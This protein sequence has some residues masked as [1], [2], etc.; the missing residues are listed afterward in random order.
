MNEPGT[1]TLPASGR[2]AKQILRTMRALRDQDVDWEEGRAL[3]LVYEGRRDLCAFVEQ[4]YRIYFSE[5]ARDPS[6][7][8]SL[9]RMEREVVAMTASMLGGGPG[10]VGT[11]TSGGTESI[12]MALKTAREWAKQRDSRN[13][14]PEVVVPQTAHPA[15]D[16]AAHY[17][18]LELV[19]VPV[20]KD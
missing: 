18:G 11:M 3:S 4:A 6:A 2:E 10:T 16:K 14:R 19:K 5:N 15:F 7:F 17:F 9:R 13:P 1:K 8:P 12:L 20:D